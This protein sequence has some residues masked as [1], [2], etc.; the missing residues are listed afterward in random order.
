[1]PSAADVESC[2]RCG[3][4]IRWTVTEA[5]RPLAV[6]AEPDESGNTAVHTDSVGRVRSRALTRERPD[7]D[8]LEWRAMPHPATCSNPPPRKPRQSRLAPRPVRR[9]APWRYR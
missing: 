1:M 3:A 8:H 6:N 2:D 9:A 4:D 5:G 7:L